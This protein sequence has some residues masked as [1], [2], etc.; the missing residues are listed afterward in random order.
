METLIIEILQGKNIGTVLVGVITYFIMRM[1]KSLQKIEKDLANLN[2][3][4]LLFKQKTNM[5][6]ESIEK[7]L[8]ITE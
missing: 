6:L 2:E 4:S 5:R 7:K 3:E 1:A 8:D